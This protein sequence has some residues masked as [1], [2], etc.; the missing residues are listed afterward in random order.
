[1]TPAP[2]TV[3]AAARPTPL[4]GHRAVRVALAD[5]F[6]VLVDGLVHLLPRLSPEVWVTAIADRASDLEALL[7]RAEA[8][9]IVMGDHLQCAQPE[10]FWEVVARCATRSAVVVI[11][12]HSPDEDLDSYEV[13]LRDVLAS[14][15]AAYVP[16]AAHAAELA[17]VIRTVALGY[18][19]LPMGPVRR[20]G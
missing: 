13:A 7:P 12:S 15:A 14:G 1:M 3:T 8:A 19:V 10:S 16:R 6:P 17:A 2:S 5:G 11:G 20:R 18:R 4:F 9:V